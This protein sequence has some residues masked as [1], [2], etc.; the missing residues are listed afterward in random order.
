MSLGEGVFKKSE[1]NLFSVVLREETL[2]NLGRK[3]EFTWTGPG[4]GLSSA[5]Q[6]VCGSVRSALPV[7]PD[8]TE[9]YL[10]LGSFGLV[11]TLD[12]ATSMTQ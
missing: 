10:R 11:E 12:S 7:G 6:A 4:L 2:P 3:C 9:P 5:R 1:R 8:Q